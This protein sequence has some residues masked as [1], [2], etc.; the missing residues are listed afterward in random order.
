M[1]LRKR[2]IKLAYE[3]EDLRPH[4]LP[5]L[6]R[7]AGREFHVALKELPPSLQR[8]LKAVGYR[9]KDIMVQADTTYSPSESGAA[10][11]G[12]RGFIVVVNMETGQFKQETG[13][14]GGASPFEP[15]K[16]EHDR[17]NYPIPSNGAVIVGEAG[18][19]GTFASIKVHP[20]NL[21]QMLPSGDDQKLPSDEQKAL[22]I[23]GGLKGGKHRALRFERVRLGPYNF[24]ANPTLQSLAKKGL[25]KANRAGAMAITTKGRNLTS[26]EGLN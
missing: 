6:Q 22:N 25:I 3:R 16:A 18:G 23:I 26:Q 13:S 9:R 19:R 2:I 4:L 1:P 10:F 15:Q 24:Q 5:L 21:A 8:A 14:W 11:S 20:S 17:K 7:T 12:S